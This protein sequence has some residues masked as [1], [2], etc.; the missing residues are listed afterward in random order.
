[1]LER[2]KPGV[3]YNIGAGHELENLELARRICRLADAPESLITFVPDRPGHDFRYGVAADR[4]LD[5]GW[6]PEVPFDEGLASTVAWYRD[7]LEWLRRAH[8]G[9]IVTAPREAS[10]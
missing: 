6:R 2:G 9:P 5:L 4:V 7:H 3:V 10:A 1:V 8:G